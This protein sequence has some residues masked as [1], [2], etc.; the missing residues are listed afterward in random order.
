MKVTMDVAGHPL[1]AERLRLQLMAAVASSEEAVEFN[2]LVEKLNVTKGNLSSHLRK[3]EDA[4]LIEAEK[5]FVGRRPRTTYRC[6]PDG[7]M[8]L[9]LYLDELEKLILAVK[10]KAS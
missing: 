3:L 6:T 9:K 4:R 10:A 8:A 2:Q 7:R 1:L 5:T